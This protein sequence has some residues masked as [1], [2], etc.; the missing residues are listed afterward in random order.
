MLAKRAADIGVV[1]A[2]A[3]EQPAE[4]RFVPQQALAPDTAYEQFIDEAAAI[5]T[6]ENAHDFFNAL[7]WL[8]LPQAKRRMNRLQATEIRRLGVGSRRGRVRD[9]LT[10]LDENG[11]ILQAP[12]PLWDALRQRDWRRLFVGERS[13]WSQARLQIVG[14]A[15]LEQLL[16]AP[17][18]SLT[19]HVLL[20]PEPHGPSLAM[21]DDRAL[22]AALDP[23]WL[24][25]KP[26]TPLPVLGVPGWCAQ[27][28]NFCFYDDSDVFRPRRSPES[29]TTH[30]P[31][32]PH[33]A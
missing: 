23:D 9:A 27:N 26:F 2:L 4:R 33:P 1:S 16:V 12:P 20:A 19:A 22:A 21:G 32:A 8:H 31:A 10:L 28:Q 11:A 15:L 25:S 14:H 6:R 5:P 17:R 30:V 13:L 24:A 18:K 3:D 7:V 29:R